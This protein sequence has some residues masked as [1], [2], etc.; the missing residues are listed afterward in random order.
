MHFKG[1]TTTALTDG[2]T[3]AAVTINNSSYTPSA[4]DV[5]LY[6][7]K[8]FVWTGSLWE[9]LGDEGSYKIK[10]SAVSS[11]TAN[12]NATAFIDTI[13]Q[14]ANG[15]ITVTKRNLDTSGT[16][17][18]NATTA[19]TASKLGSSNLGSATKPIYL[20]SGTATE[21]STYA[22][23]TAVT[24]NNS[25]KAAST[26][27]FYAPTTGGTQNTQALIGNGATAA[28]KWVNI[29]PSISIT[30]GTAS[31]APKI[32]V[33]VLGQSGTAQSITTA[34]TGLYGVTK[35]NSATNS[36]S[37]SEAATPSA[38]KSAYDLANNHKYWADIE[39]TSA[40]TY[41]KAPEMA[42]IK[43]NGNTSASAASTS[44]VTL[45]FDTV[46]QALNFVF[47]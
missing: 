5:V 24:L 36:T 32:N 20:A 35:L 47:A 29:S 3:T 46:L 2:T 26:A 23:G 16:W 1:T 38:V 21:C 18:G 34:T 9:L 14:D 10:Q 39:A 33:T 27:S 28:P 41:N 12:G 15:A 42:T 37:T 25:S 45:V 22:G 44:N 30:A 17:S 11:P 7:N 13:S 43:L 4:G 6:N 19:T 8:E 40:A 31:A